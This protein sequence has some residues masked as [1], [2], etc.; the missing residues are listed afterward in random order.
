MMLRP[1]YGAAGM[2]G[3]PILSSVA[4]AARRPGP[5]RAYR[6]R[7]LMRLLALGLFELALYRPVLIWAR[8]LGIW[9]FLR[10]DKE[11]R[12]GERNGRVGTERGRIHGSPA[13]PLLCA[14]PSR[15]IR[16]LRGS[17][18]ALRPTASPCFAKK[19]SVPPGAEPLA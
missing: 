6:L 14:S 7:D 11:W 4:R 10:G 9:G 15:R 16:G 1:R 8:L 19:K 2:L 5:S 18:V 17:A 12:K 13:G 3:L